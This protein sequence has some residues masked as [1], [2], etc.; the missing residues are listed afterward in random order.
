[1]SEVLIFPWLVLFTLDDET[2]QQLVESEF[3]HPEVTE[4]IHDINQLEGMIAGA[5]NVVEKGFDMVWDKMM[6]N[7]HF[8]HLHEGYEAMERLIDEKNLKI[9]L[10][11][12]AIPENID[13]IN[14]ITNYEIRHLDDIKSNFG[15]LDNRAYVVSIFNQGSPYPQQAFFSN[16]RVFIDKQ[17]TLFNQL[18]EIALPIKIRNRELKLKREELD[19]K[20]T[21]DNVGEF[22][23]EIIAQLEHCKRELVIFSSINILVHFTHF[24][25]FWRL[26]AML[27]KQNVIIKI[28]TDDFI[29]GILNQIHKLNNTLFRDV[30]QIRNSGKLENIDEC[31]MIIDGKLI[32]RIINKKNDTSR[33]FGI[34]STEANHVLVQ[35]ILFEKY[36][37]EVQS[38][39]GISYH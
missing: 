18:W 36:W 38:L 28:L 3:Y 16:S 2:Y 22:Q 9:R 25:S 15:I 33:F 24:E 20:K 37:N 4:V 17:Q 13:Q 34:L 27:A 1:M 10:I 31:V 6:F 35:E 14:S 32:F 12:E 8:N 5:I 39:S 19:F 7:F 26:C 30:I 23:S 21:F 29:P 11:V